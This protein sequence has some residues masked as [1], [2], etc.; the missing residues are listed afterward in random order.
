[1]TAHRARAPV[2]AERVGLEVYSLLHSSV[3]VQRVL[4]DLMQIA[5]LRVE[6]ERSAEI[7]VARNLLYHQLLLRAPQACRQP[8]EGDL[9]LSL[10]MVQVRPTFNAR[11]P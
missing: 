10:T 5:S 4:A 11:K 1:M 2:V 6:D 9:V 3:R 7:P 8:R